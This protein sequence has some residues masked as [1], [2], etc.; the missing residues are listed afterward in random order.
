MTSSLT[1]FKSIFEKDKGASFSNEYEVD[2]RF[3]TSRNASLLANLAELEFTSFTNTESA[4]KNMMLLCDEASLPGQ[5]A[6]TQEIDGIYTGRLIQYP[7]A[8]LYNDFSLSF[9]MTN[10]EL[11][12]KFF[13]TWF[14]TMFPERR[15]NEDRKIDYVNK[16]D[17]GERTNIVTLSYYDN[18]VCD[19]IEV[20][21]FHKTRSAANGKVT[22]T[23]KMY[24]AYPYS[25]ESVPLAYGPTVLNKFRVQFR[26]EKHV[27]E[28]S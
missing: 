9:I 16:V 22:S 3:S 18:I 17:R 15:L 24:R 19:L 21:K 11:P 13:E 12:L 2:I 8:K 6:A 27:Q 7:H 23:H 26:Y 20:R 10:E 25:I 5:F 4:Y 28:Y 1:K 14:Y